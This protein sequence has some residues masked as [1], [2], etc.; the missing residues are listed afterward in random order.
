M[1][2]LTP[3]EL[4]ALWETSHG[5]LKAEWQLLFLAKPQVTQIVQF[6]SDQ[7][8]LAVRS[9]E[10]LSEILSAL[11][12]RQNGVFGIS[13]QTTE[14]ANAG[15]TSE[16][17]KSKK[18]L[19]PKGKARLSQQAAGSRGKVPR[20]DEAH[21]SEYGSTTIRKPGR[22]EAVLPG[23]EE[24]PSCGMIVTGNNMKCRCG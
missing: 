7:V 22:A 24:C 4:L 18:H 5:K 15:P 14:A 23:R 20:F 10:K 6:T 13:A 1:P 9:N 12:S 17:R 2:Y 16:W 19:P 8:I 3:E 11:Q 21:P